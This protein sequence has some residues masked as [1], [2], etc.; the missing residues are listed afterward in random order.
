MSRFGREVTS[1]QTVRIE[2]GEWGFRRAPNPGDCNAIY[3]G[4]PTCGAALMILSG[5]E[6]TSDGLTLKPIDCETGCGAQ[7]HALFMG[8]RLRSLINS[9]LRCSEAPAPFYRPA[10]RPWTLNPSERV[11]PVSQLE[12]FYT[13][14]LPADVTFSV[15]RG[16]LI[17]ITPKRASGTH[18]PALCQADGFGE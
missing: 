14:K 12:G 2:A 6:I 15:S 10:K 16:C 11:T 7:F 9:A 3:F 13:D 8:W 4:C 1:Y 17:P 18:H 5:A